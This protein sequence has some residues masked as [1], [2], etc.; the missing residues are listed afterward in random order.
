MFFFF[1][2]SNKRAWSLC[3]LFSP[4]CCSTAAGP[5]KERSS[6]PSVGLKTFFYLFW[7]KTFH[8]LIFQ[9]VNNFVLLFGHSHTK[10]IPFWFW[11]FIYQD[12]KRKK[13]HLTHLVI[14]IGTTT[15]QWTTNHGTLHRVT[16][17]LPK[18]KQIAE[19]D[20]RVDMSSDFG[21]VIVVAHQ[22]GKG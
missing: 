7:I 9:F 14:K 16:V 10:N 15:F 3:F 17:Y 22:S 19:A 8:I 20:M 4:W 11:G 12:I 1:R 18:T 2:F 5:H 13:N 21:E 6:P